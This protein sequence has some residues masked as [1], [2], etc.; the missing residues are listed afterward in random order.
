MPKLT[1]TLSSTFI[2][3]LEAMLADSPLTVEQ[4]IL[5]VI[6]GASNY[7]YNSER[8]GSNTSEPGPIRP[9]TKNLKRRSNIRAIKRALQDQESANLLASIFDD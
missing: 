5:Q 1:L 3:H 4:Y 7:P 9:I 6:A 2:T 8:T